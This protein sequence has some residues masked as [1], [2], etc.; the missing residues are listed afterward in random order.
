MAYGLLRA[1]FTFVFPGGLLFIAALGFLRPHGLPPWC[2]GP[3][4]ALPY[5]ALASG[6]VF[7][8]YFASTRMLLSVLSLTFANQALATWPLDHSTASVS[9]TIFAASTFLLHVNFLA[10]SFVK[11]TTIGTLQ[12]AVLVCLFLLQPFV[13]WWLCDPAQQDV[14]GL[15]QTAYVPGWSTHWTPVPQAAGLLPHP[16]YYLGNDNTGDILWIAPFD[17]VDRRATYHS[18]VAVDQVRRVLHCVAPDDPRQ[19][20][21]VG[22]RA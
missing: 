20:I 17:V 2:Q 19:R 1:V 21:R 18:A 8:W 7:G 9:Q 4:T 16:L 14:A 12:G 22:A 11:E 3:I 15:L 6:L 13:V 5:L 10:F